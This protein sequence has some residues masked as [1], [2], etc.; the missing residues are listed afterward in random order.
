MSTEFYPDG[1]PVQ[2]DEMNPQDEGDVLPEKKI[3]TLGSFRVPVSSS[4]IASLGYGEEAEVLEVHFLTGET[5]Q[6]EGVPKEVY[7]EFLAAPSKGKFFHAS[8]REEY[9]FTKV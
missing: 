9:T 6:Y 2:P 8:V 5:Y 1:E 7:E 3:N 4:N